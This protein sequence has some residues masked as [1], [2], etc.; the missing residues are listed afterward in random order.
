MQD[1]DRFDY[2]DIA[3]VCMWQHLVHY[4]LEMLAPLDRYPR[5]AARV[6]HLAARDSVARTTPEASLAEATA[7][8]WSPA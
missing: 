3:T 4:G 2:A 8:G 5:L 6:A 1:R 7:A